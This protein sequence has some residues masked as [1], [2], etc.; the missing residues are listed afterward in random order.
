MTNI[1]ALL[2]EKMIN[3]KENQEKTNDRVSSIE[4]NLI[5]KRKINNV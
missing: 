2:N 4:K 1:D 5:T 3:L